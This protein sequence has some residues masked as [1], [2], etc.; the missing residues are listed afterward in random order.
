MLPFVIALTGCSKDVILINTGGGNVSP[1]YYSN[2]EMFENLTF[3]FGVLELTSC[4]LNYTFGL[5]TNSSCGSQ[6]NNASGI[7]ENFTFIKNVSLEI[8]WLSYSTC[9]MNFTTGLLSESDC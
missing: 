3:E 4:D 7:T 1:Y 6:T 8:G 2:I 9:D 5:L